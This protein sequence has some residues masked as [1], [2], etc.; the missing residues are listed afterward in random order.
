MNTYIHK[1]WQEEWDLQKENKLYK[2]RPKLK[3]FLPG[4]L[5]NRREEVVLARLHVGHTLLT[6]SFY[7]KEEDRPMCPACD[8]V[9]SVEHILLSCADLIDARRKHYTSENMKE[10]FRDVPPDV[11]FNF[12]K[13]VNV[14]H[15][16]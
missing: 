14:F 7:F 8:E 1:L 11:I 13:E 6:H 12:L 16:I 3:E 2:V 4:V 10:L 9:L 15:L 5:G